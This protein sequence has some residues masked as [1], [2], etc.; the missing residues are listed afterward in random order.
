VQP[1]Q[2]FDIQGDGEIAIFPMKVYRAI[3][4]GKV[5]IVGIDFHLHVFDENQPVFVLRK[6]KKNEKA[7]TVPI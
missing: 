7:R 2:V 5:L 4:T 3:I 6:H 1:N